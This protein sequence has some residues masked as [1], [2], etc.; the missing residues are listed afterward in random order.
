MQFLKLTDDSGAVLVPVDDLGAVYVG[1][2]RTLVA[3][4]SNPEAPAFVTETP[5]Q[6]AA[7]LASIGHL[8]VDVAN[9][10]QV[11]AAQTADGCYHLI[12]GGVFGEMRE[13]DKSQY[14]RDKNGEP[15]L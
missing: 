7:A 11:R 15:I 13:C 12:G 14:G 9:Q 3:A 5:D 10:I 8:V 4:K 6:I 1:D 2:G